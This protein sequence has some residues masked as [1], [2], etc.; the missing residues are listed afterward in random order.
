MTM[1]K[2]KKFIKSISLGL[3][4]VSIALGCVACG[5]TNDNEEGV[6]PAFNRDKYF[7]GAGELASEVGPKDDWRDGGVTMEWT[8]STTQAFGI[9]T[10]R[11][12]MHFTTVI[13]RAETSNELSLIRAECDRYHQYFA[14][15]KAKGVDRILVMNHRY[16]YPFGY[17]PGTTAT[18]PDPIQDASVYQQWLEMYQQCYTMI[19]T[20]FPEI[21]FWECGNEFDLDSFMHKTNYNDD[22]QNGL[23]SLEETAKFTAELCYA[24]RQGVKAVDKDNFIVLP[25]IS[26]Y[27]DEV[28]F[29]LVYKAIESK[30]L[31]TVE[32]Y[33]VT[34]PD[35]Y[36]DIIAWHAYPLNAKACNGNLEKGLQSFK[37][38][39]LTMY[40]VAK[41][42]GD[43][44][45]RVWLTEI[46]ITDASTGIVGKQETLEKT[47]EYA[48]RLL[49]IVENDL[50]FIETCF[51]FRYAN[52]YFRAVSEGEDN[53]GMFYSPDDPVYFGKPKP[54]AIA[55]FKRMHGENADTTPLYWYC[56]Q[57]GV[58]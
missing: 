26:Q 56:S 48:M 11:V 46:G 54:L 33:Y 25:G 8:S 15:L 30:T 16:I 6:L 53:F 37:N 21:D 31:P 28:F 34:D 40:D 14:A 10:Q 4:V 39:C 27:G 29:N 52:M 19:A 13:K 43:G 55:F 38:R 41:N 23:Y 42:H 44:D 20:E 18:V 47:A 51:W 35:K 5:T 9:K 49:D 50:P 32:E 22:K 57:Y 7:Y 36:F 24:A 2:W 58:N 3:A 45:K 1:R 17:N 12:W